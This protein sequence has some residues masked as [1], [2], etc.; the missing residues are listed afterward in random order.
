MLTR[1]KTSEYRKFIVFIKR[2][3]LG[4][5]RNMF[6]FNTLTRPIVPFKIN[7][8]YYKRKKGE[9]NVGDLL[10]VVLFRC[11]LEE[12]NIK[13]WSLR[14]KR[15]A[16]I[17]SIIQFIG[18]KSIIFGSGFLDVKS[19]NLF[20][21]KKPK[22]II[23]AVRG[24]LTAQA[25]VKMGYF[26]PPIYGDPAILMPLFYP[27]RTGE[28]K[29]EYIV[30]PH[31][32]KLYKYR[33]HEILST[34]TNDWKMFINKICSSKLVVS[35]S[36]HGII[37]AETYGIPAIF[38]N[39]TESNDLFK[40]KDYYYSTGRENFIIAASV[41]EALTYRSKAEVPDLYEQRQSLRKSFFI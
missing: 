25:L 21:F 8:L 9:Q 20:S 33:G 4:I 14:T 18:S 31:Y 6:V 34:L 11:L 15:L 12:E 26:V 3:I 16:L 37:L 13:L 22:L 39:D 23:R 29:Y 17:G 19:V 41:R 40:Y 24:P 32:S 5:V 1:K 38:L 2:I 35:A 7:L 28:K 30:I 10:S 27:V 36:L